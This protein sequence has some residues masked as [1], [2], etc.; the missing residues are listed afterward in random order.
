MAVRVEL[1]TMCSGEACMAMASASSFGVVCDD[2]VA[3]S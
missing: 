1:F 3:V 2:V